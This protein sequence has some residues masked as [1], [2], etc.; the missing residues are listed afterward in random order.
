MQRDTGREIKRKA[1]PQVGTDWLR[2][3]MENQEGNP[4]SSGD[5]QSGQQDRTL[6]I[7]P[8]R[9]G[10]RPAAVNRFRAKVEQQREDMQNLQ[11][12]Q[13]EDIQHRKKRQ[14]LIQNHKNHGIVVEA[15][16]AYN[17]GER[18]PY[19]SVPIPEQSVPE[20]LRNPL[21][22][23]R[24]DLGRGNGSQQFYEARDKWI[25]EKSQRVGPREERNDVLANDS[26]RKAHEKWSKWSNGDE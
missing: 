5:R 14:A 25:D 11:A 13:R 9:E 18:R 7:R 12:K 23:E 20:H 8:P 19:Q 26:Y 24:P 22:Q 1:A 17:R 10:G 3:H 16:A 15:S 2:Q 6:A 4:S 21:A